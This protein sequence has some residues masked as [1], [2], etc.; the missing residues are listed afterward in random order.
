M[1]TKRAT[2]SEPLAREVLGYFG[3]EG[4]NAPSP[5]T[6]KALDLIDGAGHASLDSLYWF[7]PELVEAHEMIAY[8]SHGTSLLK[9]E[10][11]II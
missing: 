1:N 5:A 2:I 4:G 9:A 3:L 6:T 11:G 10:A 7:F 8:T